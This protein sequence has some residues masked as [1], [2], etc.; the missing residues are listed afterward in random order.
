VTA[1]SASSSKLRNAAAAMLQDKS[2]KSVLAHTKIAV[3][4]LTLFGVN[5]NAGI[6]FF[7][8][9]APAHRKLKAKS[10]RY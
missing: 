3:A 7:G 5:S 6:K 8:S 4:N 1:T 9:L 2:I 10:R